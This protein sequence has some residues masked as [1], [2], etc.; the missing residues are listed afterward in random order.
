MKKL[1]TIFFSILGASGLAAQDIDIKFD[2]IV[3]KWHF[4]LEDT[5]FVEGSQEVLN[6]I[7][8]IFP[9][10]IPQM[11]GDFG[12]V[13][14]IQVN[15]DYQVD[16]GPISKINLESGQILWKHY[17]NT[18][19]GHNQDYILSFEVKDM[20]ILHGRKRTAYSLQNDNDWSMTGYSIPFIRFLDKDSGQLIKEDFNRVDTIGERDVFIKYNL[21]SYR[22]KFFQIYRKV[23][24]NEVGINVEEFSNDSGKTTFTQF[25]KYKENY[26]HNALENASWYNFKHNDSILITMFQYDSKDTL[27]HPNMA[28]LEVYRI[29]HDTFYSIK[30]VDLSPYLKRVPRSDLNLFWPIKDNNGNLLFTKN[31]RLAGQVKYRFCQLRFDA[32]YNISVYTPEIRLETI[33]YTYNSVMP[34]YSDQYSTYM[35]GQTSLPDVK[36]MDVLQ[37]KNDGTIRIIGHL[38]T[39]PD[40]F[41]ITGIR[42]N[43]ND[44][45]NIILAGTWDKK[46]MAV[47]GFHISDFGI[48]LSSE[49]ENIVDPSP[50]MTVSPNPASDDVT[51]YITDE[52][53]R[54]GTVRMYNL[55]GQNVVQQKISHGESLN[56]RDLP[57]GTYIVQ[58]S[59][60]SRPGYFLTT[61]LVKE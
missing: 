10:Q 23:Q 19:N 1:L 52:K 14:G 58:F 53:Y 47:M 48:N 21:K 27:L 7:N 57:V 8:S 34:F 50:L 17:Y 5:N 44:K 43:M 9:D 18:S 45:G 56:I 25:L 4:I 20:V 36:G 31:Y 55:A 40:N 42:M 46:A 22:D 54:Q 30:Y 11:E 33:N 51:L 15:N 13:N 61:K 39:G 24:N 38:T 26:D 35:I 12:Y 37:V 32:D 6:G 28:G 29:D 16:G 41:K 3:P 2:H 49:D 59:P 60:D